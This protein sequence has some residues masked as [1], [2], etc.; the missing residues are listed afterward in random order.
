MARYCWIHTL[1][2]KYPMYYMPMGNADTILL[3]K[4][5]IGKFMTLYLGAI[6]HLSGYAVHPFISQAQ[7][8]IGKKCN[9]LA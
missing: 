8:T 3:H 6:G 1:D 2:I 9:S 5:T 4:K 7:V